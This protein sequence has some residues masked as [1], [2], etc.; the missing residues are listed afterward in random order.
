MA[1]YVI[2][3]ATGQVVAKVDNNYSLSVLDDPY[4]ELI[5]CKEDIAQEEAGFWFWKEGK[6]VVD[7]KLKWRIQSYNKARP[8]LLQKIQTSSWD[9]LKPVERKFILQ[10]TGVKLTDADIE[11]L[12]NIWIG[13]GSPEV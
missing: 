1:K 13:W 5:N 8:W 3:R 6:M 11:L 2:S 4:Y 9:S 10:G 7:S 12:I